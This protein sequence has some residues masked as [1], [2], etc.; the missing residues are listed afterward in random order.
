MLDKGSHQILVHLQHIVP[1]VE[2]LICE[3][4]AITCLL[5]R[6]FLPSLLVRLT[7]ADVH[8]TAEVVMEEML[9]VSIGKQRGDDFNAVTLESER[10]GDQL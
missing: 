9:V 3:A 1:A 4:I 6:R 10:S 8:L 2:L 7:V 5:V